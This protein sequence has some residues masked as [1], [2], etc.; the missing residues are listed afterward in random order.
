MDGNPVVFR[1]DR[2]NNAANP[3]RRVDPTAPRFACAP[4]P[5]HLATTRSS[6]LDNLLDERLSA[7]VHS[8][9]LLHHTFGISTLEPEI[10]LARPLQRRLDR[11]RSSAT[12]RSALRMRLR[13]PFFRGIAA[14]SA[15][16][17]GWR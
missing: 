7:G 16:A 6:S 17:V 4:T 9:I 2:F 15:R 1:T 13:V 11:G 14:S 5:A 12:V 8:L 10:A 3:P